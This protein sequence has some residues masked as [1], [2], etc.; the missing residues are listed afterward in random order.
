[1]NNSSLVFIMVVVWDNAT[2]PGSCDPSCWCIHNIKRKRNKLV[3]THACSRGHSHW[4]TQILYT[5]PYS[6]LC[7]IV[8]G[9]LIWFLCAR[10]RWLFD[11]VSVPHARADSSCK[12]MHRVCMPAS[13]SSSYTSLLKNSHLKC[14]S[15]LFIQ[16]SLLHIDMVFS[17]FKS[18]V[19]ICLSIYGYFCVG[20]LVIWI[21]KFTQALGSHRCS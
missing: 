16:E 11:Y 20:I 5:V 10:V 15:N 14:L 7:M 4:L 17:I 18:S 1:M 21:T 12:A 19:K 9:H 3:L 6:Y 8:I 13:V 2:N